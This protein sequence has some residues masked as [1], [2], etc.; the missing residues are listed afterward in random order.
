MVA[1]WAV[2]AAVGV[3]VYIESR[4]RASR[5]QL[6]AIRASHEVRLD[7]VERLTGILAEKLAHVPTANELAKLTNAVTE[8]KGEV[9]GTMG[10]FRERYDSIQHRTNRIE[11]FLDS[12]PKLAK[13]GV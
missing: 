13:A 2:T 9:R 4:S 12:V 6:E 8:L 1:Q 7:S 3:Y 10:A 5:D 11:A